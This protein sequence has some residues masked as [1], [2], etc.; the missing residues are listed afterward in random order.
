MS[1]F[2]YLFRGGEKPGSPEQFQQHMEKWT[3]WMKDL[4]VKGHVEGR[5][6]RPL[7]PT[8]QRVSGKQKVVTDGSYAAPND[9][10]SGFLVVQAED[11]AQAVEVSFGCPELEIGGVVEVRPV[12][13]MA[14]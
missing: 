8:G 7:E 4:A 1:E 6:G 2:A 13:D 11:L 3:T 14:G 9:I 10:V 5:P 12:M